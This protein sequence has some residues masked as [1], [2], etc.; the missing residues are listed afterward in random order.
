MRLF[1]SFQFKTL[2]YMCEMCCSGVKW[3]AVPSRMKPATHPL[4]SGGKGEKQKE[5]I[6]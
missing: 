3:R 4:S 1:V 5:G 6:K 2:V